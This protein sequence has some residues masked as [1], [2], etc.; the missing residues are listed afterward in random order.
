[1]NQPI[2]ST[3]ITV[4]QNGISLAVYQWGKASTKHKTIVFIHGYP[5]SADVWIPI[6]ET[7][8]N[9]FHI[10]T[11]DVRGTGASTVPS[12]AKDY[13]L[14]E[15]VADIS[16][17][18]R[19]T[20]PNQP[21]HLVGHDW[22]AL[23]GW[24]A[25]LDDHLKYQIESYT[26]LAPSLDKVGLWFHNLL[27]EN[28]PQGYLRLSKQLLSSS[29]MAAF[30]IPVIPELTW[31]LGLSWAW[32]KMVSV[33]ERAPVPTSKTQLKNSINGIGLYRINLVPKLL[34][35]KQRFTSIPVHL[36]EMTEDPFVPRHFNDGLEAW[37]SKL[38]RSEVKAGHWGI[39]SQPTLVANCIKGYLL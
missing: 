15:L 23:Q 16:A 28:T 32:P 19:A 11:Y 17:V 31:R 29:Y 13:H 8:A 36:I 35:P 21:V 30:Q 22:G 33:L 26:A 10:V 14:D 4:E 18:I 20:S 6:A 7:L 27:Q 25:V 34:N 24:E 12:K 9:D 2:V 3:Q 39:S 37:T 38:T 5:D 1:M